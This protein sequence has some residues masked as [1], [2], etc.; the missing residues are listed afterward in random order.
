MFLFLFP[1]LRRQS[2]RHCLNLIVDLVHRRWQNRA[3][4]LRQESTIFSSRQCKY[5]VP[6]HVLT[7]SRRNRLVK[8]YH[9]TKPWSLATDVEPRR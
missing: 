6:H 4:S 2:D 7:L 5:S 9:P 3:P 8:V 1:T